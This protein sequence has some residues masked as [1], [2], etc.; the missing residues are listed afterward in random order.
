MVTIHASLLVSLSLEVLVPDDLDSTLTTESKGPAS[1]VLD[2]R[3]LP[4]L[5]MAC[6]KSV[7]VFLDCALG[8]TLDLPGERSD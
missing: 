2:A 3:R 6:G 7:H 4:L 1:P 5:G 8:Q